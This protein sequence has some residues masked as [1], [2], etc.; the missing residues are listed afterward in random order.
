MVGNSGQKYLN[1]RLVGQ[2]TRFLK[3]WEFY[4]RLLVWKMRAESLFST[5]RCVMGREYGASP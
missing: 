5:L 4:V 1:L 3:E 2:T